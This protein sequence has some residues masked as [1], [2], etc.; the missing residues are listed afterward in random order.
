MKIGIDVRQLSKPL[1]GIGRYTLEMCRALSSNSKV[2][3]YLY[4]P[5]PIKSNIIEELQPSVFRTNNLENV[6][7]RQFWS[8]FNLPLKASSDNIDIFWGPAHKLPMLLSQTIPR[9][10]T[11]HDLVWKFYGETMRPLSRVLESYQSPKSIKIADHIVVDSESVKKSVLESFE[12]QSDRIT[13]VPLGANHLISK[14]DTVDLKALGINGP[15]FLFVGTVEPRKNLYNL[16]Y[17]YSNLPVSVREK[18]SCVIAGGKGWGD[19]NLKKVISDLNLTDNVKLLGYVSELELEALYAQARFLAMP[20]LYEGFG[21]PLV[22]AML[23]GCPVITS[24]NSSM[25]EVTGDAGVLI[26]PLN[27]EDIKSGLYKLIVDDDFRNS[28]SHIAKKRSCQYNWQFSGAKLLSVFQN[29]IENRKNV[30][31]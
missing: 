11:I 3:L 29:V 31:K 1:T 27:I 24:N 25:I 14:C 17:A 28:L 21:L 9:V 26:D 8:E 10:V 18:I 12:I 2:T 20:S 13:V 16:L 4:S 7:L 19:I 15:Y 5:S 23:K 6:L 30:F 22:E